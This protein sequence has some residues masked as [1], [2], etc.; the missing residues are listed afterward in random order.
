MNVLT[1]MTRIAFK[2]QMTSYMRAQMRAC[3]NTAQCLKQ[4]QIIT[5]IEYLERQE[6]YLQAHRVQLH[7]EC[8][9]DRTLQMITER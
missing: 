8:Q 7:T 5:I 9:T 3:I 6:S 4:M 2:F 1:L